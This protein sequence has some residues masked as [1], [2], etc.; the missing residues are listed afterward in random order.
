MTYL[1]LKEIMEKYGMKRSRLIDWIK[2]GW[3]KGKK[4]MMTFSHKVKGGGKA[5]D[6]REIWVIDEES[7]LKI[8]E[9]LR[10]NYKVKKKK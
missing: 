8:P 5:E 1:S 4:R 2:R 3:V 7:F 10:K 6:R 9:F